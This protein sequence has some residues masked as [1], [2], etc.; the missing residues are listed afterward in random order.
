ME[1]LLL[2]FRIVSLKVQLT[3]GT[4][5]PVAKHINVTSSCSLRIL[6][7]GPVIIEGGPM[8]TCMCDASV[9]GCVMFVYVY[10]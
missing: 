7:T 10:V 8:C 9:C 4:G 5:S 6:S 3:V 1:Y 2:S